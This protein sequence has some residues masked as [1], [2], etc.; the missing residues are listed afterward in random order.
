[1]SNQIIEK[2]LAKTRRGDAPAFKP[3]DTVRVQVKIK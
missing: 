3:G 2:L 1:M